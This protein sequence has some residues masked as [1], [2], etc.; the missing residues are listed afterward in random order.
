M[1]LKFKLAYE[2]DQPKTWAILQWWEPAR[3]WHW[4]TSCA[5]PT[6]ALLM[7]ADYQKHYE[8]VKRWTTN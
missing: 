1:D 2:P 7:L 8:G 4:L 5:Y 3:Q 6:T